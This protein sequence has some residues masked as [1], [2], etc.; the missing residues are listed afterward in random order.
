MEKMRIFGESRFKE[1]TMTFDAPRSTVL[2]CYHHKKKVKEIMFG[3]V[4]AHLLIW[5]R[6]AKRVCY[7]IKYATLNVF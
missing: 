7:A 2:L 4:V 6:I 1:M 3:A 5:L